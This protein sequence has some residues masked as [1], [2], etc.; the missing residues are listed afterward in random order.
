[1]KCE[2]SCLYQHA[3][4]FAYSTS[5]RADKKCNKRLIPANLLSERKHTINVSE[6]KTE[7]VFQV[8]FKKDFIPSRNHERESEKQ[9]KVQV[10]HTASLMQFSAALL[11][12]IRE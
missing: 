3:P 4:L 5:K 10:L 6:L 1:M 2:D 8:L 7:K 11:L 12:W 9:I